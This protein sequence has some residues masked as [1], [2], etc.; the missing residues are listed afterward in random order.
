MERKEDIILCNVNWSK[1]GP[2]RFCDL[3][4]GEVGVLFKMI[5]LYQAGDCKKKQN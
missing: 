1:D 3:S 5:V 4:D 2:Y